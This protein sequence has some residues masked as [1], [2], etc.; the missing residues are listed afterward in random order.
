MGGQDAYLNRFDRHADL[1][2]P[3]DIVRLWMVALQS[4]GPRAPVTVHLQGLV[5][6]AQ[7][8]AGGTARRKATDRAVTHAAAVVAMSWT[9]EEMQVST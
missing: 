2:V 9:A 3:A 4:C 7:Q 6:M 5:G 8:S 1:E